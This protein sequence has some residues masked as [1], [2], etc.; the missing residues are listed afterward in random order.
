M[1]KPYDNLRTVTLNSKD[2]ET[3]DSI[4]SIR[5]IINILLLSFNQNESPIVAFSKHLV[6]GSF[7]RLV[8]FWEKI[9]YVFLIIYK[10]CE[11][12]RPLTGFQYVVYFFV[13]KFF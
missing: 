6:E 3:S 12:H 4:S 7:V 9:W 5:P 10:L 8:Y 11:F 1:V 13:N 2:F